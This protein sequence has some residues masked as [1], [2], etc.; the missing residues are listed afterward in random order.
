MLTHKPVMLIVFFALITLVV[1]GCY[2][3]PEQRADRFVKHMASELNLN[4]TQKAKLDQ[5]KDEFLAK[6]PEMKKIREE[7]VL[8]ANELMRSAEIDKAKLDALNARHAA[9]ANDLIQFLSSKFTEIHDMLTPEQREKLVS[10]IEKYMKHGR[11][12][13]EPVKAAPAGSGY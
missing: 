11:G 6:R 13:S 1:A 9:H 7:T 12:K 4:D 8:E 2:R 10:H 3:T 5:I